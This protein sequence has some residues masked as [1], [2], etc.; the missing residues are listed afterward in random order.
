MES[1]IYS[2]YPLSIIF[3]RTRACFRNR[4]FLSDRGE[5]IRR[6]Y[7]TKGHLSLEQIQRIDLKLQQAP[8]SKIKII[9][10]HQPFYVPFQNRRGL[11][12][13]P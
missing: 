9:V 2:I 11:R 5:F 1:A 3:R 8:A 10:S 4:T 13:F 6:R 12:I 7:H